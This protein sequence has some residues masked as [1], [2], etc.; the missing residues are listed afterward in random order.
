MVSCNAQF[1]II[2]FV[3]SLCATNI[4]RYIDICIMNFFSDMLV[5]VSWESI[6]YA[7][8]YTLVCLLYTEAAFS[9]SACLLARVPVECVNI[10]TVNVGCN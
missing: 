3:A 9:Q 10:F 1:N 7:D 6:V 2:G 8:N 5:L 4:T